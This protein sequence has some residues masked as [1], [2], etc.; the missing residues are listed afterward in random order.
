LPNGTLSRD[1]ERQ[2][3]FQNDEGGFDEL[4]GET[5]KNGPN[6]DYLGRGM[7]ETDLL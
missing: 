4:G 6:G 2:S 1:G 3:S 7:V 5:R